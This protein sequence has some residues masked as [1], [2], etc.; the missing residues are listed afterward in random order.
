MPLRADGGGPRGGRG[1]ERD[2]A[3]AAAGPAAPRPGPG[4]RAPAGG[5]QLRPAVPHG[6]AA[7]AER[8]PLRRGHGLQAGAVPGRATNN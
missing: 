6:G 5:R 2:Q 1:E 3:A 7:A 4:L 8:P